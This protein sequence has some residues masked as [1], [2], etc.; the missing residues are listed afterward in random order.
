V[1]ERKSQNSVIFLTALGVYIGLLI[2]GSA[3]GVVAQQ[4]GAM[5]KNF[6]VKD[7]IEVKEKLDDDPP[8]CSEAASEK[9]K[10]LLNL[11]VLSSGIID[12]LSDLKQLESLGK[13]EWTDSFDFEFNRK[14][15]EGGRV[16]TTSEVY[17]VNNHNR[18]TYLAVEDSISGIVGFLCPWAGGCALYNYDPEFAT[19]ASNT[20]IRVRFDGQKTFTVEIALL[21]PDAKQ[22]NALAAVFSE[23][24]N[25]GSCSDVYA[26]PGQQI[27]YQYSIAKPEIGRVIVVTRLPRAGLDALLAK[28]AK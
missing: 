16:S 27:V 22:A 4:A 24:F 19:N 2:A 7:E 20:D 11:N 12:L 21:Q 9:A 8:D 17:S 26:S 10:H 25:V 18:W 1:S 6:N 23:A 5:T 14:V 15:S 3:P 28:G 13:V